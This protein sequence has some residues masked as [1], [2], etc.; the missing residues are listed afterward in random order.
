MTSDLPF[1]FGET[2]EGEYF[3]DRENESQQ[4]KMNFLHGINSIIISPRRWGKSS[5]VN[6]VAQEL[7]H[8]EALKIVQMD[9]FACRTPQ[10]FYKLF[11][12]EIIKQTSSRMEEWMTM[13]KQFLSSLIPV[14]TANTDPYSPFSFSLKPTIK[15]YSEEVL[16]LPERIA[17]AKGIRLVIC[18]DEFQQIGEFAHA[19]EFQKTLRK[20]W[21]K[22]HLTHYCLFGSKRH[23]LMHLF[24]HPSKPFYKFGEIM[25]L[26]RIPLKYWVPFIC[27]RFM[28]SGKSISATIIE[29]LYDYVDGNSSYMQQ[30]AWTIW[31]ITEK[32]V[33][34]E[35][36]EL[37]KKRIFNQTQPFFQEQLDRLTSYQLHFLRAIVDGYASQLNHRSIIDEYE[38]GSSANVSIIKKAL[39]QKELIDVN[40]SSIIIADPIMAHW[41]KINL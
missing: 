6:K 13:A 37:A 23:M 30:F 39:I 14:V 29:Q 20:Y 2:A 1:V 34:A 35:H 31:S 9:A 16:T 33:T 40:G 25:F 5:L 4:L 27:E 28:Q 26:E 11:A 19:L 21:Q 17:S 8:Q 18:I 38:L 32:D 7:Q 15:E 41:L 12:V 24:S 3:T 36:F 22:Q 10:D